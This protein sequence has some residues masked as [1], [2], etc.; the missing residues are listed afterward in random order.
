MITR[1]YYGPFTMTKHALKAYTAAL[2]Q[3]LEPNGVS[4]SIVQPGGIVTHIGANS[5]PGTLT[6]F[7]RTKPPFDDE[8]QQ[9][10]ASFPQSLAEPEEDAPESATL[11]KPSSPEIISQAT[12]AALYFDNPKRHYLVGTQWEGDRVIHALIAKR[13]DQ[14]DDPQH[15]FHAAN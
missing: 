10:L 8:A 5:I 7:E 4:V 3:K 14:N 1:K 9:V 12:Y 11:R 15:N 2:H 13:L 6:R